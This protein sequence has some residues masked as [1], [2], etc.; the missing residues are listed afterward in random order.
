[1][2][3]VFNEDFKPVS[4]EESQ[5]PDEER[6]EFAYDST[7]NPSKAT[8]LGIA[9]GL[10]IRGSFDM[11]T[12]QLIEAIDAKLNLIKLTERSKMSKTENIQEIIK[13]LHASN[14]TEDE[15]IV[16]I[17]QSGVGYKEALSQYERNAIALGIKIKPMKAA[18]RNTAVAKLLKKSKFK[19][20]K[21]WDA[22]VSVVNG[23]MEKLEGV[24]ASSALTSVRLYARENEIAL[25]KQVKEKKERI[26]QVAVQT[27][28]ILDSLETEDD[29][30]F[31]K[32]MADSKVSKGRQ[33]VLTSVRKAI[34]EWYN[35]PED[36]DDEAVDQESPT[37]E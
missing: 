11:K 27:S 29:A 30:A 31:A 28:K 34:L 13:N 10:R 35:T 24:T 25:P 8:C 32:R 37:A 36:N 22:L 21:S 19:E 4:I 20:P 7:A 33:K 26:D 15:I 17:V 18:E 14:A 5:S 2:K 3:A 1:M 9:R 16:A 6:L 12:P 23:L